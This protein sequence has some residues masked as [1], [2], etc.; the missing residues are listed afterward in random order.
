VAAGFEGIFHVAAR[1]GVNTFDEGCERA[2]DGVGDEIDEHGAGDEGHEAQ[3]E[4]EMVQ[5]LEIGV[6][7]AVGLENDDVG[8]GLQTRGEFDGAGMIPLVAQNQFGGNKLVGKSTGEFRF[9]QQGKRADGNF[10]GFAEDDVAG[11]DARKVSGSAFA[12]QPADDD[13]AKEIFARGVVIEGLKNDLIEAGAA[14][15]PAGTFSA[16]D[17][18]GNHFLGGG[19]GE[20]R[21]GRMEGDDFGVFVGK[22]EEVAVVGL[23]GVFA[24]VPDG[25]GIAVAH[26]CKRG[27]QIG[28]AAERGFLL[29]M[30]S[31]DGECGV[32]RIE[33]DLVLDLGLRV[34]ANDEKRDAGECRGEKNE[35]KEELGAKAEIAGA[36]TQKVCDRAA[37]QE[38]GAELVVRHRA[39]RVRGEAVSRNGIVVPISRY[40]E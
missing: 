10:A 3:A 15:P 16:I 13:K 26:V 6:G 28:F 2:R 39:S 14:E 18:A 22:D 7:F 8:D 5:T 37:G 27:E 35:R 40:E 25:G 21:S 30:D 38:P 33:F 4:E 20:G 34:A 1:K 36:V 23:P 19:D 29:A 12:D 9:F 32:L 17:G 31:L 11:G 24:G